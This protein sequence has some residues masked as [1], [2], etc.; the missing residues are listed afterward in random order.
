MLQFHNSFPGQNPPLPP[1]FKIILSELCTICT[2]SRIYQYFQQSSSSSQNI[3]HQ[4]L[5]QAFQFPSQHPYS[6]Y[7]HVNQN[8]ILSSKE[9]NT[10]IQSSQSDF[11]IHQQDPSVHE[12]I[13]SL[14]STIFNQH[15]SELIMDRIRMLQSRLSTTSK[16]I[17]FPPDLFHDACSN[18]NT[19]LASWT[20]S[21]EFL[22]FIQ[23]YEIFPNTHCNWAPNL[24]EVVMQILQNNPNNSVF[25]H[26]STQKDNPFAWHY[27]FSLLSQRF[28][29][30][31]FSW[32]D[33]PDLRKHQTLTS[34]G[35]RVS[36]I[37][38]TYAKTANISLRSLLD[39]KDLICH[40]M[41]WPYGDNT[42]WHYINK[43]LSTLHLDLINEQMQTLTAQKRVVSFPMR[44]ACVKLYKKTLSSFPLPTSTTASH[45]CSCEPLG[46]AE[47]PDTVCIPCSALQSPQSQTILNLRSLIYTCKGC[48]NPLKNLHN[49]HIKLCNP[50]DAICCKMCF[51]LL[52]ISSERQF[53]STCLVFANAL[54]D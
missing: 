4:N 48:E 27:F 40:Q 17:F 6:S 19:T 31:Y 43:A 7:L 36:Q 24:P 37:I 12:I 5:L 10:T 28:P 3:T 47:I 44:N 49:I 29:K 8:A 39:N 20:S 45:T 32:E 16:K 22:L 23:T 35:N 9:F 46:R 41:Q 52:D 51:Q 34:K 25:Q 54:D 42:L 11:P 2:H 53:C 1:K 30:G 21:Q 15:A 38:Q 26:F 18:A 13:D 33:H 14:Q 50:C